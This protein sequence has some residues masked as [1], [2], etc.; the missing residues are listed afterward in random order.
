MRQQKTFL[1]EVSYRA[2]D[3]YSNEISVSR[4]AAFDPDDACHVTRRIYAG[5]LRLRIRRIVDVTAVK[6]EG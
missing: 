2:R 6:T 1:V 3:G 5:C 4:C